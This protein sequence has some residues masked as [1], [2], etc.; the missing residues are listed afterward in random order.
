MATTDNKCV[1]SEMRCAACRGGMEPLRGAA[2]AAYKV[3]ID[4]AWAIQDEKMLERCFK[5]RNFQQALDFTNA[6]GRLAEEEGHHPEITVTW[7]RAT[8]RIWTHKIGGLQ[9]NDF[10]LA[11]KIDR[12]QTVS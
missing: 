4:P 1:L 3:Q 2:L 10:I 6:V 11:A 8:V 5:F 9:E 12:L 7:G